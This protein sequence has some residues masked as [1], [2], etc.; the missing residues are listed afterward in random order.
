MFIINNYHFKLYKK[1]FDHIYVFNKVF[2]SKIDSI[3]KILNNINIYIN[4]KY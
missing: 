3:K 2:R 1:I 4:N